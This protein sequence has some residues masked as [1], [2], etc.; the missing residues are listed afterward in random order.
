VVLMA[1]IYSQT[2]RAIGWLGEGNAQTTAAIHS[3]KDIASRSWKFGIMASRLFNPLDCGKGAGIK[4]ALRDLVDE[5]DFQDLGA[6][7]RQAWFSRLWVVQEACLPP[8]LILWN[9]TNTL[10][11]EDFYVSTGIL[12]RLLMEYGL[13]EAM[14]SLIDLETSEFSVAEAFRLAQ[15]RQQFRSTK[16]RAKNKVAKDIWLTVQ[17]HH[18]KACANPL[19]K[20]YG[21]LGL[22]D[23]NDPIEILVNYDNS[24]E[25]LYKDFAFSYLQMG[26][27]HVLHGAG[28]DTFDPRHCGRTRNLPTWV[29]DWASLLPKRLDRVNWKLSS[30][31]R[32]ATALSLILLIKKDTL[33]FIGVSG[34]QIDIVEEEV[35]TMD[36]DGMSLRDILAQRPERII[37]IKRRLAIK[38]PY[39]AGED[40]G[41]AFSRTLVLDLCGVIITQQIGNWQN[42]GPSWAEFEH[43]IN[44][45]QPLV[46]SGNSRAER[47]L[48][49]AY[50][51]AIERSFLVTKSGY[52]GIGP[53]YIRPGDNVVVFNGDRT[54]FVLRRIE[55]ENC[56]LDED[57][58]RNTE[59]EFCPDEQYQLIGDCYV[60][61]FMDNE[62]VSPKWR[63]KQQTFWI[64]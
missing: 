30:A 45:K 61:G 52:F 37:S 19:D 40:T 26:I 51:A 16:S 14:S 29:T 11:L 23:V 58:E 56:P 47:F 38:Q 36:P 25:E 32:A 57:E 18:E 42:L 3:I 7:F 41:A 4:K 1:R 17:A 62:V 53:Q 21:L 43:A 20:I 39:P 27:I 10:K 59:G 8:E 6:F 50:L 46:L 55:L 9:G 31:F 60:H 33:P 22:K 54:P 34:V 28:I 5:L 15:E 12:L 2:T 24:V 44:N 49:T 63:A 13:T 64:R 35:S 48:H